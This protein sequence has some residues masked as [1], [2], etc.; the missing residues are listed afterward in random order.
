M[1]IAGTGNRAQSAMLSHEF[2]HGTALARGGL[3]RAVSRV[4]M[5]AGREACGNL[6][7]T[8]IEKFNIIRTQ[9]SR[10]APIAQMFDI[11]IRIAL[12]SPHLQLSRLPRCRPYDHAVS[13]PYVHAVT[14]APPHTTYHA[15]PQT[16][17]H[18][19]ASAREEPLSAGLVS[20]EGIGT[21]RKAHSR[22]TP[23]RR[24]ASTLGH[25]NL[26]LDACS[27]V[28]AA[29]LSLPAR[30]SASICAAVFSKSEQGNSSVMRP[31][32]GSYSGAVPSA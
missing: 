32:W 28:S 18:E 1:W 17:N 9:G 23:P 21:S 3:A 6:E 29:T 22:S 31:K 25:R 7:N 8:E 5:A 11:Y 19:S 30:S 2:L 15:P 10:T 16:P 20:R 14:P 27:F 26:S 4:C 13:S 12:P 24:H